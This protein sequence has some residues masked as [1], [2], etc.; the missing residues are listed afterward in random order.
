MKVKVRKYEQLLVTLLGLMAIMGYILQYLNLMPVYTDGFRQ[1][2]MIHPNLHFDYTANLFW[3]RIGVMVLLMV[4]YFWINLFTLPQ[5]RRTSYR[6]FF[7]YLWVLLQLLLLSYLLAIGVNVA[8]YYA[9]PALNNYG[10]FS[11]FALF[12]YNENPLTDLWQGFNKALIFLSV[13]GTYA[14][15]REYV[16]YRIQNSGPKSNYRILIANQISVSICIF[17][18]LPNLVSAFHIINDDSI[19]RAYFIF[20]PSVIFVY[21]SNTYWLFTCFSNKPGISF[22]F[23]WR[24]VIS[25]LFYSLPLFELL[26]NKAGVAPH[27]WLIN[28]LIQLVVITPVTWILYQQRKDKIRELRGVEI[29]LSKSTADLQF[30]RSQINPH[31]LFN[32]LNTIYATALV[33]GSKRTANAIQ[34]LGDMMRF[35]LDDNHLDFIP[36]DNELDY[37]RNYIALQKLRIQDSDHINISE[38]ITVEDFSHQIIPMLLIPFIENAFKHGINMNERSWVKINLT[39][40]HDNIRLEVRNSLH[41]KETNDPEKKHTG[42]GLQNVKERLILFYEGRHQLS[43]AATEDEFIVELMIEPTTHKS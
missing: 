2:N 27:L 38:D 16:I 19:Y 22:Q 33:D 23:I 25:T 43:Y 34:M 35:M 21:F 28:A 5:I 3:P 32:V 18:L 36:L 1:Y 39:C 6:S 24:L 30:L 40:N 10:E 7:I 14:G 20:I 41:L 29:A 15:I 13:Y 26:L 31:F 17:L 42:I 37:L 11:L 4:V 9:H 12:G 8:T